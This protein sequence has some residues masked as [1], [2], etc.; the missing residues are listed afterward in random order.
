MLPPGN[1]TSV[2]MGTDARV[3]KIVVDEFKVKTQEIVVTAVLDITENIVLYALPLYQMSVLKTCL[4]SVVE[5]VKDSDYGHQNSN[6]RIFNERQDKQD[7]IE[8][9]QDTCT[10]GIR[11]L[12]R[13]VSFLWTLVLTFFGPFIVVV[14]NL[15]FKHIHVAS[16]WH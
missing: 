1:H 3:S 6:V 11:V 15:M 8:Y 16:P 13:E 2:G 14:V 4:K 9:F 10:S 12:G 5:M 7:F